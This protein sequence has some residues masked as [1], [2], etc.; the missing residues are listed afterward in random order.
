V[1]ADRSTVA[2]RHGHNIFYTRPY[3]DSRG[4]KSHN[5]HINCNAGRNIIYII[6]FMI[7]SPPPPPPPQTPKTRIAAAVCGR[8]RWVFLRKSERQSIIAL[9]AVTRYMHYAY[10]RINLY[11]CVRYYMPRGGWIATLAAS[12]PPIIRA[13]PH[14]LR[15]HLRTVGVRRRRWR[16]F[17]VCFRCI[18]I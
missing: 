5:I 6:T 11:T 8:R 3:N 18:G 16:R 15:S 1:C 17:R 9:D 4:P 2:P 12:V 7:T 13:R 14:H 10:T